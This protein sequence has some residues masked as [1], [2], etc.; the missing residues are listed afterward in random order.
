MT[1]E[2]RAQM[3]ADS[4]LEDGPVLKTYILRALRAVEIESLE[5]AAKVAESYELTRNGEQIFPCT[6]VARVIRSLKDKT[7]DA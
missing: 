4:W 6:A 5:R 7:Q 3:I 2:E 1:H